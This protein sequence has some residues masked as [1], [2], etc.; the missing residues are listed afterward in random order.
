MIV[1]SAPIDARA[2]ASANHEFVGRDMLCFSHD[3]TGDPLSKTHLM[4]IL[5]PDNRILWVNSIGYRT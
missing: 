5:A 4:R 3:W 2:A 1:E